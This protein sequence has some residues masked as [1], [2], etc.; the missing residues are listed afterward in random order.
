MCPFTLGAMPTKFARTVAA[1]VWGRF[2]HCQTV[3]PTANTAPTR[4]SAPI[5]RPRGRRQPG[6]SSSGSAKGSATEHAQPD[7][8]G[9]EDH[10]AGI[11]EHTRAQVRIEPGAREDLPEQQRPQ[12]TEHEGRHPRWKVRAGH[13]DVRAWPAAGQNGADGAHHGDASAA[14]T[15][16]SAPLGAGAA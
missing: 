11:H 16:R 6:D 7:N 8:Q 4:M 5:M 2:S 3:S 13:G 10:E 12:D 15:Y 1:S 14:H 9:D